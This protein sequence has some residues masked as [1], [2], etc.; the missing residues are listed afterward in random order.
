MPQHQ[1]LPS[2]LDIMAPS[3]API[4]LNMAPGGEDRLA[5]FEQRTPF[6][7]VSDSDPLTQLYRA[8]FETGAGSLISPVFL[9]KQK[10]RYRQAASPLGR[11]TNGEVELFWQNAA[12]Q[13]SRSSPDLRPILLSGQA[14]ANGKLLPFRSLFFCRNRGI[15]FH[16]PC[17]DCGQ[18]LTLCQ[19]DAW[20][21]SHRLQPYSTSLSRYLHCPRC[22]ESGESPSFFS[23][24]AEPF[25]PPVVKDRYGL[26]QEWTRMAGRDALRTGLPCSDC[27]QAGAC[28]RTSEQLQAEL[29]PF[30]FYPFH[31]LVFETMTFHAPDFLCLAS[32][33]SVEE[34]KERLTRRGELGKV[35]HLEAELRGWSADKTSPF[36]FPESKRFFLE[37]LH[38][39]LAFLAE[40]ARIA[41]FEQGG[42]G[43]VDLVGSLDRI[44]VGLPPQS[45][46]LPRFWNFQVRFLDIFRG[47]PGVPPQL[48]LPP[49]YALHLM[50]VL[51]LTGLLSNKSQDTPVI[52]QA[53]DASYNDQ[54]QARGDGAQ[55]AGS[56]HG[57]SP[58]FDPGNIFWNPETQD[59]PESWSALWRESLD[60]GWSLMRASYRMGADWSHEQF[61]RQLAV[62]LQ[63]VKEQLFSSAPLAE[64][65]QE[66]DDTILAGI[67]ARILKQWETEDESPA[68]PSSGLAPR[69]EGR[70]SSVSELE[71]LPLGLAQEVPEDWGP[72][73]VIISPSTAE[74]VHA[75]K[76]GPAEAEGAEPPEAVASTPREDTGIEETI[77]LRSRDGEIEDE[78]ILPETVILAPGSRSGI[79]PPSP[80]QPRMDSAPPAEP[81][82]PAEAPEAEGD[83][84]KR[85]RTDGD[86]LLMET[87]ILSPRK[88]KGK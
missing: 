1:T 45:S 59:L 25:D 51:W 47:A 67:L 56:S 53:I 38:L 11:L 29:I 83:E 32:G 70:P 44:W 55:G 86:E 28:L 63:K 20:L 82:E 33:G 42:P 6:F 37:V 69:P 54:V 80:A 40:V 5:D 19:D 64:H 50:G 61:Q 48:K 22:R 2:L 57:S 13:L 79:Q 71:T 72:E 7:L 52:Q 26:V 75:V 77:V 18:E 10:D 14:D 85:A 35:N 4:R 8:R 66:S 36:F 12:E 78:A 84:E 87:V 31:L 15:Y 65:V 88:D 74:A 46:S 27:A 73:T 16:P 3:G 43:L 39:K 30:A 41:I 49:T 34:L 24:E 23:H 17:P 68:A 58:V 76:S 9:L 81:H 60:L 21:T 62:L